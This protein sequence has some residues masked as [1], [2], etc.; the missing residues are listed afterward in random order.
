MAPMSERKISRARAALTLLPRWKRLTF[1]ALL[2]SNPRQRAALLRVLIGKLARTLP[3]SL[4]GVLRGASYPES[5]QIVDSVACRAACRNCLYLSYR[6][7][8]EAIDLARLDGIF[9]QCRPLNISTAFMLGADPFYRPDAAAFVGLLARHRR[10]RHLL[11]TD[12]LRL[13]D[14]LLDMIRDAGNII[15]V[16]NVD[17][18]PEAT[19]SRKGPGAFARQTAAIEGVRRRRVMFAVSTMVSRANFEEVTGDDYARFVRAGGAL[20]LI[21]LPYQA[22]RD[23]DASL[24]VPYEEYGSL[25]RRSLELTRT[26]R[27]LV[28]LD[29]LGVEEHL[30]SCP[31]VEKTFCVF[32][33]GTVAPCYALP[34]GTAAGKVGTASLSELFFHDPLFAA[35]RVKRRELKRRGRSMLCHHYH[36]QWIDAYLGRNK[37]QTTVLAP[38]VFKVFS[39]TG[40]A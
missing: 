16:F 14:T 29:L 33:D 15:P 19:D 22:M 7:R 35:F 3:F 12:G 38:A 11:F 24:M 40:K 25:F 10:L 20:F 31:A 36:P 17:G 6:K 18:G 5:I 9:T 34:A 13:T 27:G 2:R 30:T 21:Y 8:D 26:I 32:H 4:K 28:V 1:M 37:D 39:K 23:E